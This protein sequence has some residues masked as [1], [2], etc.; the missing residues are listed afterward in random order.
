MKRSLY[1]IYIRLNSP[2][3]VTGSIYLLRMSLNKT[4]AMAIFTASVGGCSNFPVGLLCDR[5]L[6][7]QSAVILGFH[8]RLS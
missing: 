2:N 3:P 7:A 6:P 4:F 8:I 5:Q 1:A